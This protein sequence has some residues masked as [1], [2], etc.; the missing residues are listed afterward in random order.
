MT[1]FLGN[2]II[3][4]YILTGKSFFLSFERETSLL[5]FETKPSMITEVIYSEIL[6]LRKDTGFVI[7]PIYN[8][9]CLNLHN[10]IKFFRSSRT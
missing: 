3:C 7:K 2:L 6:L 4:K 10:I 8:V 9:Y 5:C 1:F